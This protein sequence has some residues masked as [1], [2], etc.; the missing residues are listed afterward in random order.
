MAHL[1]KVKLVMRALHTAGFSGNPAK[2][3]FAQHE[4]NFLGHHI[5]HGHFS[6]ITSKVDCMLNYQRPTS[7]T[8]LRA[9]LGLMSY[10]RRFI[11]NFSFI[12]EPLTALTRQTRV[13]KLAKDQNG[14]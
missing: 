3:T 5:S 10:Y 11:R 12:A 8:E 1:H 7:L 2:C 4:I 9:F 6:A 14:V 13:G